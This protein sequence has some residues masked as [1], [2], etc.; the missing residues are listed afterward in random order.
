MDT[1]IHRAT[2][3]YNDFHHKIWCELNGQLTWTSKEEEVVATNRQTSVLAL[4]CRVSQ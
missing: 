1:V 3:A 4:V 2:N